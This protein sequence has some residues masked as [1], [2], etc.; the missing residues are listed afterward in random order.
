MT[1]KACTIWSNACSIIAFLKKACVIKSRFSLIKEKA[2]ER[3]GK[4]VN[5]N[6]AYYQVYIS[7]SRQQ[8]E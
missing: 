1:R 5:I 7:L 2:A 4:Q 6:P 3:T 8:T